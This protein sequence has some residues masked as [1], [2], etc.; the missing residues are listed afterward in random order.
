MSKEHPSIDKCHIFL[1]NLNPFIRCLLYQVFWTETLLD[2]QYF[3]NILETINLE[4][5]VMFCLYGIHFFSK[6]HQHIFYFV[7]SVDIFYRMDL[8]YKI[9]LPLLDF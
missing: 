6:I 9:I 1:A 7:G 5:F 3:I 8:L 2:H 4:N